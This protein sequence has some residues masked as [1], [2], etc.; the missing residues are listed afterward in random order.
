MGLTMAREAKS[1]ANE[2]GVRAGIALAVYASSEVHMSITKA[3]ALLGIG[4]DN[5]RLIPVDDS[6]RMDPEQLETAMRRDKELGITPLAV[7]ATAGTVNTGAIDPLPQIAGI[8]A[9]N[10]AWLH[11][12]G[13]YGALGAIAV[14]QKFQTWH[15]PTLFL[16][17]HK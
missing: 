4:R 10:G 14:P 13:A 9:K 8:A 12:D 5:L 7:I 17:P 15:S 6:F 2:C 11:V 3:I 1:P 16:D